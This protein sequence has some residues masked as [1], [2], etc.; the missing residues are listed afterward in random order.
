MNEGKRLSTFGSAI[1]LCEARI[2]WVLEVLGILLVVRVQRAEGVE[3]A[4]QVAPAHR[5]AHKDR[6]DVALAL[7]GGGVDEGRDVVTCASSVVVSES[8]GP[9]M[10][11]MS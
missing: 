1:E 6:L 4:Q 11:S 7:R 3:V 8:P 5:L 9:L 10:A 2:G